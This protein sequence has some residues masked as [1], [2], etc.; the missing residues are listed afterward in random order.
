MEVRKIAHSQRNRYIHILIVVVGCC[1]MYSWNSKQFV[2]LGDLVEME[3]RVGKVMQDDH[4]SHTFLVVFFPPWS[5]FPMTMTM[6]KHNYCLSPFY[7]LKMLVCAPQHNLFSLGPLPFTPPP[8]LSV[9]IYP[10]FDKGWSII[11]WYSD[12]TRISDEA[13]GRVGYFWRV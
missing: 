4:Y 7:H 12:K 2:I 13:V 1:H 8:E 3:S 5:N 9:N 10:I 6:T 11:L